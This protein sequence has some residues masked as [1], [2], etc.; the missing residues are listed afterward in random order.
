MNRYHR[1]DIL[2][3]GAAALLGSML[4]FPALAAISNSST[5]PRTLAFFNTHTA[6]SVEECYF[7]QGAYQPDALARINYVLRDHRCD[8]ITSIDPKLLDVLHAVKSRV[9]R[10]EPFHVISGYRTPKSN[11]LLRRS[12]KGVARNSLHTVGKAVDIRVP[13]YCTKQLRHVCI[14]MQSGGVGYY[15]KSDFVHVDTGDI[16]TW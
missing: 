7:K 4:P 11:E 8:A 3:M 13:G 15:P 12:S 5:S 16:R 9:G 1:R 14:K 6:E 10:D 2:K